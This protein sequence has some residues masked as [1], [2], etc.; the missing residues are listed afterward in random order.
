MA[1]I[2]RYRELY[3]DDVIQRQASRRYT[4]RVRLLCNHIIQSF[5][6]V[7]TVLLAGMGVD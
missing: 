1:R 3:P 2:T 6:R 7:G 4:R 5:Q